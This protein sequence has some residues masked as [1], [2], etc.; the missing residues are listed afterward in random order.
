MEELV[1][2][3]PRGSN[4]STTNFRLPLSVSYTSTSIWDVV[5][6]RLLR[7]LVIGKRQ[8]LSKGRRLT[9]TKHAL[10]SLPIYKI[11]LFII[12][13]RVNLKL[14]KIQK[15]FWWGG[16][17]ENIPHLVNRSIICMEKNGEGLGIRNLSMFKKALLSKW[18]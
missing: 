12:P 10:S 16:S 11:L 17:L 15:D 7:R 9:M 2:C 1:W 4:V 13:R 6:E 3:W 18:S 8:Y 14:M 5:E